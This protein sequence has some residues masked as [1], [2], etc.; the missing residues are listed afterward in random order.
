MRHQLKHCVWVTGL[1][2]ALP[3]LALA[4]P[5]TPSSSGT[6]GKFRWFNVT[7][8]ETTI[9]GGINKRGVIVGTYTK[10][11]SLC[12]EDS[13]EHGFSTGDNGKSI[14][15]IEFPGATATEGFGINDGGVIAGIYEQC[16]NGAID[17]GFL[18]EDGEFETLALPPIV[19]DSPDIRGVN[20]QEDVVGGYGGTPEY[21][22]VFTEHGEFTQLEACDDPNINSLPELCKHGTT[23]GWGINDKRAAVGHYEDNTV[24][25]DPEGDCENTHHGFMWTQGKGFKALYCD[26]DPASGTDANGIN[27]QGVIVGRCDTSAFVLLPP[28]R[29][30]DCD[31]AKP[32]AC[33]W[34]KFAIPEPASGKFRC[35]TGLELNKTVAWGISNAG[36]IVGSY[37]CVHPTNDPGPDQTFAFV[38]NAK[39][40]K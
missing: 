7:D 27:N 22:F 19:G 34:K 9:A 21:G 5:T 24:V 35:P 8:A 12:V 1:L 20:N 15:T 17:H 6:N 26:G 16:N 13:L 11:P 33:D 32:R 29:A 31:A 3:L 23:D 38:V 25:C 40:V 14:R 4:D 36:R 37:T 2:L 28:Y 30:L 10:G 39:D 18:Y